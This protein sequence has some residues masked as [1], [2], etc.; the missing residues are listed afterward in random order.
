MKKF[1]KSGRKSCSFDEGS[2][3]ES[4]RL[5]DEKPKKS[6]N[7]FKNAALKK[8]V[9]FSDAPPKKSVQFSE[10]GP[11]GTGKSFRSAGKKRPSLLR[12]KSSHCL[13]GTCRSGAVLS[14][15]CSQY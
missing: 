9:D 5:E 14:L 12:Q 6:V 2:L 15:A 7:F 13:V 10:V 1:A 8:S 11:I 3:K 4:D